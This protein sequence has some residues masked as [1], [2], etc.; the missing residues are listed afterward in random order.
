MKRSRIICSI[1]TVIY[2]LLSVALILLLIKSS[3]TIPSSLNMY[4]KVIHVAAFGLCTLVYIGVKRKLANKM[5]NKSLSIKIS[6]VYCYLY[7]AIVTLLSRFVMAYILKDNVVGELEPGFGVGLGSY[8]NYGL[9][10][11]VKNK[12]YANVIVNTIL[13][14]AA[15]VLI[16]KIMLNI[17][18]NDI[19][20]TDTSMLYILLPLSLVNVVEYVRYNYNVIVMLSG[21]WL[22]TNI[23]D[24]VKNFS[25]KSNKYLIY[26]VVFGLVQALDVILGG[27]Y[28]LWV[29]ML[30]VTALAAMYID[31]VRIRM[32]FNSSVNYKFKRF[33][34]KLERINIS[35]LVHVC[36]ISLVISGITTM[37]CALASNANNYQ[38]FSLENAVNVL[39][40][41]RTY[42]LVLV[43]CSLV[44]EVIG[45]ILKRKLDIKMFMV[46]V[47]F[48]ATGVITFFMVDG[49]YASALFDT[50]LVLTVI[51]NICNICYN[52]EERVKLLKDKN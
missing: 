5:S 13:A 9:G 32:R 47:A 38:I 28:V 15:S 22:F 23:I 25:K 2:I 6:Q 21:L 35:K 27:S 7:L 39:M 41:A 11:L 1:I 26:S 52:R 42:Y 19:I 18:D 34:E 17:T 31:S 3:V 44:F 45:I 51:T 30:V 43:I 33:A 40:H 46:K 14:F 48:I 20:S 36:G 16:K 4:L 29:C 10:L 8:I 24:E 50:L 12:M 49:I 37:I